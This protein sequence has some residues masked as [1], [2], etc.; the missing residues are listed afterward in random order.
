MEDLPAL[1]VNSVDLLSVPPIE[2][3]GLNFPLE[4]RSHPRF[5]RPLQA[6]VRSA[7]LLTSPPWVRSMGKLSMEV[8]TQGWRFPTP[9]DQLDQTDRPQDAARAREGRR[10]RGPAA[11]GR[12]HPP[13]AAGRHGAVQGSPA[14]PAAAAAGRPVRRQAGQAAVPAVS[15]SAQGHR[16]PDAAPRRPAGRRDGAGQDG[17]GHHRA[18]A[19][20]PR[21]PD[22]PGPGRLPQA[23]G[24][25][26]DA[27]AAH[28][29]GGRA[30][31]GHRRRHAE[32]AGPPGSSPTARSSWSTTSC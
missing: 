13:Q 31:R 11:Q 7:P 29:G 8:S 21:R 4:V 12:P 9:P 25:Q 24:R 20:V 16:L 32:R 17:P 27:R 5:E 18:A 19:A 14:L 2:S 1:A 15:L 6:S 28:L 26:L 3:V 30:V 23:A 10:E 22:P